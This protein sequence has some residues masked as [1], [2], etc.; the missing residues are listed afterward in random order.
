[1]SPAAASA[2]GSRQ[3]GPVTPAADRPTDDAASRLAA[4][5]GRSPDAPAPPHR[6]APA[7]A[8]ANA[9]ERARWV[10]R[11]LLPAIGLVVVIGAFVD[12]SS[13]R[14]RGPRVAVLVVAMVAL[15]ELAAP[16]D[17]TGWRPILWGLGTVL[18]W[19][20]VTLAH[21]AGF[22]L[23]TAL[24]TMLFAEIDFGPARWLAGLLG[25]EIALANIWYGERTTGEALGTFAWST[26]IVVGAVLF[27]GWIHGIIEQSRERQGLIA[28]LGA[29]RA[30][31]AA[32]ERAAGVDAERARLTGEIHDTLA[33]SFTSLVLLLQAAEADVDADHPVQPRL[34]LAVETARSGL[35]DARRLIADLDPAPLDDASLPDALRRVAARFAT[36]VGVE[37]TVAVEG[38]VR[39]L[40]PS[41]E[42]ALLRAAQESLAN[43]RKHADA[44]H[45]AIRLRF[46]DEVHLLVQDDGRGF[47]PAQDA[48]DPGRYGLRGMRDRLATVDGRVLVDSRPGRGTR[49]EVA[50]P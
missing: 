8:D 20:A 35:D 46:D 7:P 36:E 43:V 42:V 15:H 16:Y 25:V 38:Q 40:P 45:A 48:A 17:R 27:A 34:R 12:H 41:V 44:R 21:P 3:D 39:P 26:A 31:L 4:A 5:T 1:M 11:L 10:W 50:V 28:E 9:W 32:A 23:L 13:P 2:L 30:E 49:V 6:V 19:L 14:G 22:L 29:T 24:F 18:L 33:Q 47:D 37:A